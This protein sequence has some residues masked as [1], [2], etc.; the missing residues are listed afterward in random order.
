MS[1]SPVSIKR[2]PGFPSITDLKSGG[3]LTL[4]HGSCIPPSGCSDGDGSWASRLSAGNWTPKGKNHGG[5][6]KGAEK[7]PSDIADQS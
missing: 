4:V 3:I 1:V 7:L 5:S 6:E 2:K